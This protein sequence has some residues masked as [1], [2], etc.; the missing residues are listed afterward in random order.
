MCPPKNIKYTYTQYTVYYVLLK[1]DKKA[2]HQVL[3]ALSSPQ[4]NVDCCHSP[5]LPSN[6]NSTASSYFLRQ[7][8]HM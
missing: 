6:T 3:T 5:V 4:M 1:L 8:N 2:T 7:I